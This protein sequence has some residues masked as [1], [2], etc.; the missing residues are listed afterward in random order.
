MS[1]LTPEQ[2][3]EQLQ[4]SKEQAE[5]SV[6]LLDALN[7]LRSNPDF[8]FLI[9]DTYFKEEASR[10]VMLKADASFQSEERKSLLADSMAGISSLN[11]FF[12]SIT[13][14]GQLSR[15]SLTEYENAAEE[16]L[17]EEADEIAG[18]H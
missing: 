15:D 10:L 1:D 5:R 6:K 18:A 9:V 2:Q 14:M 11:M 16:I 8:Q 4:I 3:L 17:A 13:Q 7:R 12:N